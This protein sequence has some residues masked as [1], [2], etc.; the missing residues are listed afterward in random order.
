MAG[1][2]PRCELIALPGRNPITGE[3][4]KL[5]AYP[6]KPHHLSEF[7]VAGFGLIPRCIHLFCYS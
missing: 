5:V 4:R 6:R 2:V 3:D 7:Q 1:L